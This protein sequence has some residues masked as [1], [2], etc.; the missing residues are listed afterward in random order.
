[1]A[2]ALGLWLG[3]ERE[4]ASAQGKGD[5]AATQPGQVQG[6]AAVQGSA[7]TSGSASA[8]AQAHSRM[9]GSISQTPWFS[10]SDVRSQLK[11]TDEEYNKLNSAYTNAWNTYEREMQGLENVP[12]QQRAE[13][14]RKIR[15]TFNQSINQAAQSTLKGDQLNRYNQLY[16]QYQGPEAFGDTAVSQ[17]LN[18]TDAQKKAFSEYG[19]EY[20]ENFNRIYGTTGSDRDTAT[21]QYN[22][23]RMQSQNRIN[24]ILTPEQRQTWTQITG[25]SF[26]FQ[27]FWMN[28]SSSTSGSTGTTTN[29]SG[30]GTTTTPGSSGVT[31]PSSS[32][33][34]N[35]SGTSGTGSSGTSGTGGAG[36][37]GG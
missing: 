1:M 3:Q 31:N 17:K 30:S 29:P 12:A 27:P 8:D 10:S 33:T 14:M 25:Q 24:D 23:F 35:P 4:T 18:L 19:N 16:L 26:N 2:V 11:L 7:Q 34:T 21:R 22:E 28:Q 15:S 5:G 36:S 20:D 37:K 32:G 13:D 9:Y 6:K